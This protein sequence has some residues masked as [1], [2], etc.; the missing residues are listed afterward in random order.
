MS[1]A[2]PSD[3]ALVPLCGL[4]AKQHDVESLIR[5]YAS[6]H[7][8]LDVGLGL[9]G[10][11]PVP[12]AA[13]AATTAAIAAQAPLIYQPM[14]REIAAIYQRGI[15]RTVQGEVVR[16]A[17]GGG[18]QDAAVF[19]GVDFFTEIA[20]ELLRELGLGFGLAAIPFF[21]GFVGMALDVKI[22]LAM[23]WRVGLMVALYHE[24]GG[25]WVKDRKHTYELASRFMKANKNG[26]NEG[27]RV[28]AFVGEVQAVK[29][30]Q[31]ETVAMIAR[32]LISSGIGKED[33]RRK[34]EERDFPSDLI[35]RALRRC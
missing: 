33:V 19:L 3:N 14:A 35:D 21:G 9:A 13:I 34:L 8:V 20:G 22:A 31:D 16:G 25:K 24:N 27:A 15:D 17:V 26:A 23:T 28:A 2:L 18:L 29:E 12:G 4:A 11:I 10:F 32:F 5:N 7:A 30:N 6:G 1:I